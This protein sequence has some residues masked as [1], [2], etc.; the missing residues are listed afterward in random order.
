MLKSPAARAP[1]H[2]LL[3][4]GLTLSGLVAITVVLSALMGTL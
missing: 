2:S 1:S 4:I 3:C